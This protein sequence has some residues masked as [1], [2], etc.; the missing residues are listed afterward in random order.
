MIEYVVQ[1]LMY[2]AGTF[3]VIG[4]IGMLRFPDFYTRVHAAT[5]INVG[6][7]ILLLFALMISQIANAHIYGWKI[8]FIILL[9]LLT[10]PTNTHAIALA[11]HKTGIEPKRLVKAR[12]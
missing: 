3:S 12:K 11:A 9:L 5:I 7:V 10:N 2:I 4:A 1:T 8:F 6:G